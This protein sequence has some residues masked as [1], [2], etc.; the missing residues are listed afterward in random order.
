MTDEHPR[1]QF[2]VDEWMF[3]MVLKWTETGNVLET[4]RWFQRQLLNLRT[5]CGQMI[6]NKYVQDGLSLNKNVGNSEFLRTA[7]TKAD[8]GMVRRALEGKFF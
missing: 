4:V 8:I 5:S 7:W 1:P 6:M 2:S 3:I